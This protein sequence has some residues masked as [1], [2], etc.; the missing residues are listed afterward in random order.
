MKVISY[1][2]IEIGIDPER[3]TAG[4]LWRLQ[5]VEE[6]DLTPYRTGDFCDETES[7]IGWRILK[8]V[9]GV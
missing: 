8:W 2:D 4:V 3:F 5:G 1:C 6:W 7:Y 9:D